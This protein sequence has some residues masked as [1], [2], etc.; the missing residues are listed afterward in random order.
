M[1][2]LDDTRKLLQDMIA[3]DLKAIG[4]RLDTLE[5]RFEA[6]EKNVNQRFETAE[7]NVNQ[8]FEAAEKNVNQRFE[9]AEKNV[10]QR[11]DAIERIAT[12]R[13]ELILAKMDNL[14]SL[15]N[16][17]QDSVSRAMNFDRRMELLESRFG[18]L[19]AGDAPGEKQP[20]S[21]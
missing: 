9:A 4:V 13:H 14:V 21:A 5:K 18:S 10:N 12:L 2:A 11:F 6:A 8:R 1:S 16:A 20:K 15:I 7:K 3:P 17:H 19:G